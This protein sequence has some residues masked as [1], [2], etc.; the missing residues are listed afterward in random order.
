MLA[1]ADRALSWAETTFVGGACQRGE[2]ALFFAFEESKDQLFRNM[3]GVGM[4]LGWRYRRPDGTEVSGN[5][6]QDLEM[7]VEDETPAPPDGQTFRLGVR[8]RRV[9]GGIEAAG[10][11]NGRPFARKVLPGLEGQIG[12]VAIGCRNYACMFDDL[13]IEGTEVEPPE[14]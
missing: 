6:A 14:R 11:L 10:L 8:L 4:R 3:A 9:K 7:L 2:R 12:K 13:E 1:L 5:S